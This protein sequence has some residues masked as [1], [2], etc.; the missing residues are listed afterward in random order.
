MARHLSQQ[1]RIAKW[2][3]DLGFETL[4]AIGFQ[5]DGVKRDGAC[6]EARNC[7]DRRLAGAIETRRKARS[8]VSAMPVAASRTGARNARVALSPVRIVMAIAP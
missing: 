4:R 1:C 8:A 6:V 5:Y 7:A 3:R 2:P